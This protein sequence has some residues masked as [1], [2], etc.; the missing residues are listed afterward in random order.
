[1]LAR[2]FRSLVKWTLALT[3]PLAI[4]VVLFAKPIMGIFGAE[5]SVGWPVLVVGTLAQL[6]N[7]GVGS[8]GYLLLMSGRQNQLLRIQAVMAATLIVLNL[9]LIP[10]M[11]LLGAATAV[12][13]VTATTNLWYL[14]QVRR[15]LGI[16]PSLKKYVSL[17]IPVIAAVTATLLF[18]QFLASGMHAWIAILFA[19]LIAYSVFAGISFLIALDS[20]DREIARAA[21]TKISASPV[22]IRD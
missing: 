5:F 12:A 6:I 16:V 21:W 22:S 8:V 10:R 1:M 17:L 3:L 18:R 7:C 19:L 14:S 11:G 4:T 2:L 15:S 9:I 20:D 13:L